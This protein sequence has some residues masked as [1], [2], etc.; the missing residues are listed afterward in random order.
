MPGGGGTPA[1]SLIAAAAGGWRLGDY[2]KRPLSCPFS[3]LLAS[4]ALRG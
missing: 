4:A 1:A 3:P 2:Q